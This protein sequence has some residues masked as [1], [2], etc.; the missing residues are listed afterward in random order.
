MT[1]TRLS[2][3]RVLFVSN[4]GICRAPMAAG[5]LRQLVL[6]S[7]LRGRID[8]AAASLSGIHI[9]EPPTLLAIEAAAARGYDIRDMRV[10][11]INPRDLTHSTD[12]LVSDGMVLAALRGLAPHGFADRPQMLTRYSG[13]G[14]IDIVDPYGGADH[15]FRRALD[16]I[17]TC[18]R[19][20]L[21]D[22]NRRS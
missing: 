16:L 8:V 13:R 9:G 4:G 7:G 6:E 18:C 19:G 2:A 15:D 14:L 17:E 20:L 10:R 3:R 12:V 5:L 21:A 11:R 22:L 1:V